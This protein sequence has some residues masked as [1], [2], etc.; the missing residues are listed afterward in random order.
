QCGLNFTD[1]S[2][3]TISAIQ[4]LFDGSEE[5]LRDV[6]SNRWSITDTHKIVAILTG[7]YEFAPSRRVQIESFI[8]MLGASGKEKIAI[9]KSF[10]RERKRV[11]EEEYSELVNDPSFLAGVFDARGHMYFYE[12]Q[13]LHRINMQSKNI[14]LMNAI[15]K[16]HQGGEYSHTGKM[17]LS[18]GV[19]HKFL[20]RINPYRIA[21]L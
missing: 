4:K 9:G 14:P 7:I 15:Q 3:G 13:G 16:E 21:N 1:V 5:R 2:K 12:N 10:P 17:S 8:E 11:G 19:S 18:N 20:H 6:R